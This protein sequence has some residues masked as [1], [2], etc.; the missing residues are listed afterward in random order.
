MVG[1][2][3]DIETAKIAIQASLT[4]HM[5]FSTLHTNSAAESMVRL[6]D[7]GMDPFNFSDAL[8]GILAQRLAR[9]YCNSCKKTYTATNEEI[10]ALAEEYCLNTPLNPAD[11]LQQWQKTY[12]NEAGGFSLCSA[13]GCRECEGTGYKG[14]IGLYEFL[15][16]TAPIKKLIQHQA[17]VEEL[18][19]AAIHQGMRTLKQA[20]IELVLQGHTH[21]YQIRSVCT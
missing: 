18:Q 12:L 4:G 8:V 3:R 19:V 1:E 5:V 2:M 16:A 21:I 7:L 20:G 14:R 15:E 17:T 10:Q 11:V 6:L 13:G 9:R